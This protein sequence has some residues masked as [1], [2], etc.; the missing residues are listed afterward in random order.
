MGLGTSY[1][2]FAATKTMGKDNRMK[3]NTLL[4]PNSFW[5]TIRKQYTL[6]TDYIN[7][8]NG[9]Y[10]IMP[11]PIL[12]A[13]QQYLLQLNQQGAMYMRHQYEQDY[14]QLVIKLAQQIDC[15][16]DCLVITRNT[17]ESLDLVIAGMDW[18]RGDEAIMAME[19]YG[20]MLNQFRL[21]SER[22]GVVNKV[23]SIPRNP[24]SDEALVALYEKAISPK[25]K[26]IMICH[27][28]N[29]T[30]HI[31]PVKKIVDMAHRYGVEVMV[32][33]AHS[34]AHIPTSMQDL[35]CD[36][37]GSSLHKWLSAPL[38]SGVLYVKKEKISK[39]WPLMAEDI[40][41]KDNILRLGH[42]GTR[43]VHCLQAIDTALSY[44][45][46]LGAKRKEDRLRQLQ[47]LWTTQVR[48]HPNIILNTPDAPHRS[49]AIANV[50][51]KGLSPQN[52][53][54]ELMEKHK[55]FTVAIDRPTVKGCR[56]T[57]NIYTREEEVQQLA[58]AL[59]MIADKQ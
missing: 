18:E 32:D 55:L 9:Y 13:Q 24:S 50:G 40:L 5:E 34:L 7:L 35:G 43:P 48:E 30:G 54:S 16:S 17:T 45:Q 29:I 22:Y 41:A 31:L 56:I 14:K 26:L 11:Q 59:I 15:P 21:M 8:E 38:G 4:L 44:Y 6:P 46:W 42:T 12:E 57:P 39:L 20:A 58:D 36:Y 37:Y 23:V 53:A 10:C 33:G 47:R 27:M 28:V 2:T 19:D 52:L 1:A 49:C 3:N 51:I 25:T